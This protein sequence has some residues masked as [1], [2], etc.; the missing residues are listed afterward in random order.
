MRRSPDRRPNSAVDHAHAAFEETADDALLPPDLTLA[1]FAVFEEAGELRA[2]PGAA[3]RAV[4]RLARAH[5][6]VAAVCIRP[7][8]RPE[9]L[10]MIDQGAIRAG[11][12]VA[13]E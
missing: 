5:H 3:R 1:Q 2:R 9:E 11:D 7:M 10:H 6:E 4:I 8:R 13:L 12:P